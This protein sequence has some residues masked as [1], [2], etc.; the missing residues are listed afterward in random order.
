MIKRKF[1]FPL[2]IL[3]MLLPIGCPLPAAILAKLFPKE[4]VSPRFILPKKKTILVFPDDIKCPLLYPTIKRALAEKAD[5]LLIE[6]SLASETIPY[7]KLIDLRNAEPNFNQMSIPKIGRRLGAD[8]VIYVSIEDFSLKDNPINTLW[9]GRFVAMVKVVDVLK[10]RIWPDE[11]AG[12]PISID[13]PVTEN[14]SEAFGTELAR[15]LAERMAEETCG[16]FCERYLDRARPKEKETD[17]PS[18]DQ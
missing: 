9:R 10:G 11:S 12:F 5:K 7:D 2:L 1:Y 18:F 16:L 13:E 6:H 4:K 17:L 8:L 15:K 14:P 3:T